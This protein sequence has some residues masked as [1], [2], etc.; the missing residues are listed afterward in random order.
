MLQKPG[1]SSGSYGPLGS[2][3]FIFYSGHL[4]AWL[5]CESELLIWIIE[6]CELW[7]QWHAVWADCFDFQ[8]FST[9]ILLPILVIFFLRIIT[10]YSAPHQTINAI[11]EQLKALGFPI[12]SP[13]NVENSLRCDACQVMLKFQKSFETVWG[14]GPIKWKWDG[15]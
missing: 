5:R 6:W 11:Q 2:K 14:K 13:D 3:G 7:S 9:M 15:Y 1:I 10:T 12:S 4:A 8:P